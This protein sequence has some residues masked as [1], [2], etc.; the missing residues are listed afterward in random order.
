MTSGQPAESMADPRYMHIS[1]LVRH[2]PCALQT[3][4]TIQFLNLWAG[5]LASRCM[6]IRLI[7]STSTHHISIRS[8]I[9]GRKGRLAASFDPS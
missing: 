1:S 7:P 3:S 2:G 5:P 6:P 8:V 4:A 9:G